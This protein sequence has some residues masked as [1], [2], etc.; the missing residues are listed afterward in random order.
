MEEF[1]LP[2]ETVTLKFIPRKKGMAANVP[3]DHVIA[4]GML[5]N[6]K[7]GFC[8][9]LDRSGGIKNVLTKKEKLYLEEATG[10][11][12]SVYGDFWKEFG[13]KLH[14]QSANNKFDLSDPL[15][16]I[17]FKVLEAWTDVIAPNWRSKDL[18]PSYTFAIVRDGEIQND[19]KIALDF[20]KEAFKLYGKIEDDKSKLL[21][22]LRVISNKKVSPETSL[23]FIQ[24]KVETY[25]D[26]NAKS[27]LKLV[28]DPAFEVKALI[29]LAVEKEVVSSKG[30]RYVTED[31]LDLAPEGESPT[32]A[33]AIS[34]LSDP[35]NQEIKFLIEAKVNE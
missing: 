18:K 31:G 15:Q 29:A 21:A 32:Y 10:L 16:Y 20:K 12:L 7:K 25:I 17:S 23:E 34:Y 1:K 2:Q 6:S 24:G 5:E 9:P 8:A 13:V 30:G 26:E 3:D 27:F 33:N 14:K 19:K 28:K 22:V 4:G 11:N 35:A